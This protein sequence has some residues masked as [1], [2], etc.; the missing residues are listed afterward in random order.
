MP[1]KD[2]EKQFTAELLSESKAPKY[3]YTAKRDD[4]LTPSVIYEDVL[5]KNNLQIFDCDVCC[6]TFNIPSRFYYKKDGLYQHR[7]GDK[8]S[9]LD[10]LSGEWF[11]TNW[12]N[13]PFQLCQKFI[14][15]AAAEQKKGNTTYM[16]IPARV[17]TKYWHDYILDKDG[18][19]NRDG[20]KVQF[21]RKRIE[22]V[23]PDNGEMMPVFKN[24]L[25]LVKFEG[26]E[27]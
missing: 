24:P 13:P 18:G 26:E 10:G 1:I 2:V 11:K 21:L 7:Y 12:C 14:K 20:V 19:T 22:F 9:E 16:L 15:K 3:N 8:I 25:A 17:E 27:V 5:E 23:N 6:S 4:Y